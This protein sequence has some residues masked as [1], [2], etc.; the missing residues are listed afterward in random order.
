MSAS[1]KAFTAALLTA[2]SFNAAAQSTSGN[3]DAGQLLATSGN[4]QGAPACASCHGAKGEGNSTYPPLAGQ[5]TG[6]LKRQL[7]SFANQQRKHAQMSAIAKALTVQEQADVAVYYSSLKSPL[8]VVQGPLP[9]AKDSKGAWLAE[10][11][12]WEDGIPACSKCHGPAGAGVGKDFPAIAHLSGQYMNDQ[13][14]AWNS[15]TRDAGP[16]GLMGS[17]AKKLTPKDIEEVTAY[18]RSLQQAQ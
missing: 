15:G 3:I 6:Y 16:L 18:Y 5:A 11:G 17:I 7:E 13:I 10:R 12:R 4:Q 1:Y 2:A 9:T 8:K 14:K